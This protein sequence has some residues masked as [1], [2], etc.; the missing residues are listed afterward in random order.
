MMEG[1]DDADLFADL[2]LS[3]SIASIPSYTFIRDGLNRI[4][5]SSNNIWNVLIGTRLTPPKPL[6][7]YDLVHIHNPVPLAGMVSVALHCRIKGI[8]YCV[9]THGI[10]K[11]P[12][13]PEE[14]GLSRGQRIVFNHG[15]LRAYK[16]VLSN[17]THLFA[18]SE[19]DQDTITEWF[20]DQSVSV[21][22]NGV[23][24]NVSPEAPEVDT[25]VDLPDKPVLLFVGRIMAS[26][27]V[28][29]LLEAFSLLEHDCK[30]IIVGPMRDEHF[31][32]QIHTLSDDVEYRGYVEQAELDALYRRADLFVF[33]TRSDVFPLVTLE[34]MAA[35][36]PVVSTTVGGLPEQIPDQVG[37]LVPPKEPKTFAAAVD[38]M[39]SNE[40]LRTEMGRAGKSLVE[41]RYSWE[42]VAKAAVTEYYR[43]VN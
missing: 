1:K 30:L 7:D 29:D 10:S 6:S 36:T 19:G 15:F 33:P 17:A 18:L 24:L 27:G 28:D 39:L 31:K 25:K 21:L 13:I 43:I 38:G 37:R 41:E 34:A 16:N 23:D 3:E 11:V 5:A 14:L 4:F 42:A 12:K 9:T 8:P 26:K 22:P 40:Q 20:S 35:G 32:D 2:G